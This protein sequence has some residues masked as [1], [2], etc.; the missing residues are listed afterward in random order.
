MSSTSPTR[1]QQ[2][3][4]CGLIHVITMHRSSDRAGRNRIHSDLIFTKFSKT[5]IFFYRLSDSFSSYT[6]I[7]FKFIVDQGV[8]QIFE[9]ITGAKFHFILSAVDNQLAGCG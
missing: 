1:V 7:E 6:Y 9:K 2:M 5:L 8:A 3:Q 4:S